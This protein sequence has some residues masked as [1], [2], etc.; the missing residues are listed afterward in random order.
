MRIKFLFCIILVIVVTAVLIA[1][2]LWHESRR[3][4]YQDVLN[5]IAG[6]SNQIRDEIRQNELIRHSLILELNASARKTLLEMLKEPDFSDK[7][8]ESILNWLCVKHDVRSITFINR[9]GKDYH[10]SSL[11]GLN[12]ERL[13]NT[14]IKHFI[15]KSTGQG[16]LLFVAPWNDMS[17]RGA[18]QY[19]Y[20]SPENKDYIVEVSYN[21]ERFIA[22]KYG[23]EFYDVVFRNFINP[24]KWGFPGLREINLVRISSGDAAPSDGNTKTLHLSNDDM[25]KL[26][27]FRELT[28]Q[29]GS[30][31]TV[32]KSLPEDSVAADSSDDAYS[33]RAVVL[34]FD[35]SVAGKKLLYLL[36]RVII[37]I[38]AVSICVLLAFSPLFN[39]YFFSKILNINNGLEALSNGD[40]SSKINLDGDDEFGRIA[41][42]IN[43]M[44]FKLMDWSSSLLH[45]EKKLRN[46]LDGLPLYITLCDK[47]GNPEFYNNCWTK[48]GYTKEMLKQKNF[49]DLIKDPVNM[50]ILPYLEKLVSGK[51]VS[52]RYEM[53]Y[54]SEEGEIFYV[55]A[56]FIPIYDDN[57]GDPKILIM[58]EDITQ[59]KLTE[60]KL[61]ESN[62]WYRAFWEFSAEGIGLIDYNQRCFI[63]ANPRIRNMLG[64]SEYEILN[65]RMNDIIPASRQNEF[66]ELCEGILMTD[67]MVYE[68][69]LQRKDGSTFF[70]DIGGTTIQLKDR[71][72]FLMF[73]K[74]VSDRIEADQIAREAQLERKMILENISEYISFIDKNMNIV[75][76]NKSPF[77]NSSAENMPGKPCYNLLFNRDEICQ[78]CPVPELMRTG[79]SA[80]RE[81]ESENGDA[82]L[83]SVEPV[84]NGSGDIIGVIETV[85]DITELRK[86]ERQLFQSQKMEAVG[87]L[88]GGV[89][90]DFNNLLQIILGY[91]EL[92][93]MALE[94]EETRELW[95]NVMEAGNK[96]RRLV[97]Q[98]LS[99]SRSKKNDFQFEP[100]CLN[101]AIKDFRKMVGRILGEHVNL[102]I[103]LTEDTADILADTGQVEQVLMNLC[104]NARDAMPEGGVLTITTE[105]VELEPRYFKAS[106]EVASGKFIRCSV[107]DTGV[108][109]SRDIIQKIFEPFFT[110]KEI[111]KGTGLGLSTV[112]AIM[113]RHNGF[114]E[115]DSK[116]GRGSVFK[117]FFPVHCQEEPNAPKE[118]DIQID[119]PV[120]TGEGKSVLLVEDEELVR[121]YG[122]NILKEAGYKV[123]A[124]KDGIEALN[125]FYS[126]PEEF[127]LALIDAV[128]P[129]RSGKE[130]AQK[131]REKRPNIPVIFCSGYNEDSLSGISNEFLVTKPYGKKDMLR[132]LSRALNLA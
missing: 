43:D 74:D 50:R 109:M 104:V 100:I 75:W 94:K 77:N 67:S 58:A 15:D 22:E 127:D 123:T 1:L 44:S 25:A 86:L 85:K 126:N 95:N 65:L 64:Y 96:G 5:R 38:V 39:R 30:K 48:L 21:E 66:A 18:F 37:F 36:T 120:L 80:E 26:S 40:F 2:G 103:N 49:T 8:P 14:T 99:F 114:I 132:V 89:A 125:A 23:R 54:F 24:E 116:E 113:Q 91:G 42:N 78:E 46:I 11:V 88:A 10:R 130:V 97:N 17:T 93:G 29:D 84:K 16:N 53:E 56:F 131:I 82:I 79:T 112:Y 71:K 128:L 106:A 90:H 63:R 108:G 41:K 34:E 105:C 12:P 13:N 111:N 7:S 72:Y 52:R 28:K 9:R 76:A 83:I 110:T 73:F 47:N 122:I 87:K 98:L 45:S 51:E 19:C 55:R 6:V 68:Y 121:L 119:S 101:S 92:V 33:P 31:V 3:V 35:V 59:K 61:E 124:A 4:L 32:I 102:K 81:V 118:L 60:E 115:V 57:S 20:F 62:T 27:T 107:C 117:L 129:R 70:A 69:E